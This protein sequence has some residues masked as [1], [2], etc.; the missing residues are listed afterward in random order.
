MHTIKLFCLMLALSGGTGVA[1][2][3]EHSYNISD[4][5]YRAECA[6]CHIAYPPRLLPARSW[7]ALMAG[8]DKHF[9]TDASLDP[10]GAARITTF[11]EQNAGRDR[12]G[13]SAPVLRITETRWFG[14]EHDELPAR[15]WNNPKVKSAA[16]C[17]A[18]HVGADRGNF[19]EYGIR[20][21]K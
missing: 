1:M 18:C 4:P 20:L 6:S 2:A 19:N 5:T 21:P 8:L 10:P 15:V 11:L 14:H 17:T 12:R 3:G 16:N 7:R 9:G 13:S